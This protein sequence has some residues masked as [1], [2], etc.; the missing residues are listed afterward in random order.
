MLHAV[1]RTTNR[2]LC[3]WMG[4]ELCLSDSGRTLSELSELSELVCQGGIM[5]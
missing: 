4:F 5:V 2:K 3:G 1:A